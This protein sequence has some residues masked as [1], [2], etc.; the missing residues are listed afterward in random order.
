MHNLWALL[1][2]DPVTGR[3]TL[4]VREPPGAIV[5]GPVPADAVEALLAAIRAMMHLSAD[6]E[7]EIQLA[8]SSSRDVRT[9]WVPG[10]TLPYG[11][12]GYT[13]PE[14]LSAVGPGWAGL[15]DAAY[16]RLTNAG[17]SLRQ[18]K[19]KLGGLR[20][21][22]NGPATD[23]KLGV[24]LRSARVLARYLAWLELRSRATCEA[25]GAPGLECT[26]LGWE[27][28]LCASCAVRWLRG[29]RSWEEIRGEAPTSLDDEPEE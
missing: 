5:T 3:C 11:V 12:P 16:R 1:A 8:L 2:R 21:Y 18:V 28:T 22:F 26:H 29:A 10:L 20:I 6:A 14:A 17:Y 19:Q 23:L 13:L 25:C 7:I 15:V 4:R 9:H 27:R 24:P